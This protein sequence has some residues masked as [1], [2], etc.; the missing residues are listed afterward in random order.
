M[1]ETSRVGVS[2]AP[3]PQE[4][5]GCCE[6]I[7]GPSGKEG[8]VSVSPA[9]AWCTGEPLHWAE[10]E[11]VLVGTRVLLSSGH[12]YLRVPCLVPPWAQLCASPS[13]GD[14]DTPLPAHSSWR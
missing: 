11:Q 3:P 2:C 6:E 8:H 5:A 12:Q 13:A 9:V 14:A 7:E 1:G 4:E 10:W